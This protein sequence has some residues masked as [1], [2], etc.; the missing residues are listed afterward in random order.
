MGQINTAQAV[1]IIEAVT[2]TVD[3][4]TPDKVILPPADP[5]YWW[6][7]WIAL[8]PVVVVPFFLWV[9]KTL[10]KKGKKNG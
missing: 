5:N 3:A 9:K 7:M 6:L 1:E 4:A 8:A 10:S 2:A